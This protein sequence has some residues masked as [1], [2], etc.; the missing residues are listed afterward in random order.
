MTRKAGRTLPALLAL[1]LFSCVALAGCTS[2]KNAVAAQGGSFQLVTPGGKVEF[3]YPVAD[4]KPLSAISGPAVTGNKRI[5]L[6]DYP[7]KVIVLNFWG[8]WCGPCR[9]ET[10]DLVTAADGL[11]A[12]GVQFIGIDVKDSQSD[13]ADFEASHKIPY[14][15]IFDRE[16]RTLLSIRGF[17]TNIPY[18]IVLDRHHRVA[19]IWLMP[20]DSPAPLVDVASR[21]AAEKS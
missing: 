16:M 2:D 11:K 4:R 19:H 1:L 5:S 9:A 8:S 15:S 3:D 21:I 7:N 18:T 13:A 12:K 17:P 6:T 20:M 14:P 10:D